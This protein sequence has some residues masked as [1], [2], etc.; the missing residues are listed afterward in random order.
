ME[1][2]RD[3]VVCL[4]VCFIPFT[5]CVR[6]IDFKGAYDRVPHHKLLEKLSGLQIPPYIIGWTKDFLADRW[7]RIDVKG[8]I[9]ERFRLGVGVPQGSPLSPILFLVFN[10]DLIRVIRDAGG[11]PAGY[12]DD[13]HARTT[14]DTLEENSQVLAT[15][16][17]NIENWS[18]INGQTLET[19]KTKLVHFSR[20]RRP[21]HQQPVVHIGVSDIAPSLAERN[22]GLI[23]DSKLNWKTHVRKRILK[24]EKVALGT[25]L[26]TRHASCLPTNRLR[27]IF[28][29]KIWSTMTYGIETWGRMIS[30]H[31]K[32]ALKSC[33]RSELIK[34]TGALKTTPL[35]S[36]LIETRLPDFDTF[37]ETRQA[38]HQLESR[39]VLFAPWEDRLPKVDF[40]IKDTK[41][42]AYMAASQLLQY[43]RDPIIFYTDGSVKDERAALGV[44]CVYSFGTRDIGTRLEDQT[45]IFIAE[46]EAVLVALDL[47][48]MHENTVLI[49]TDCRSLAQWLQSIQQNNSIYLDPR[50]KDLSLSLKRWQGRVTICWIPGHWGIPGNEAADATAKT[51]LDSGTITKPPHRRQNISMMI[52]TAMR[53]TIA[54]MDRPRSFRPCSANWGDKPEQIYN[55]HDRF[56]QQIAMWL[57]TGHSPLNGHMHRTGRRDNPWCPHC[58]NAREGRRHFLLQCPAHNRLR[59]IHILPRLN[60]GNGFAYTCDNPQAVDWLLHSDN[61][62]AVIRYSKD[63]GRFR[64]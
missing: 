60:A 52:K 21:L 59:A 10:S 63:T 55:R 13:I 1:K 41:A 47:A 35:D 20:E 39:E 6:F 26:V 2:G 42:D 29:G 14:G 43:T 22:L 44:H 49:M 30:K 4:F 24:T 36:L 17:Q 7:A 5:S 62:D 12:A 32:N 25:R 18:L 28:I 61:I 54:R 50:L 11:T 37:F 8:H 58:P 45:T 27:E 64:A 56:G 19:T 53:A 15:V 48:L 9:G 46:Y 16:A 57:R 38:I 3:V 31:S 23:F 34:F 40:V 33:Y 51:M